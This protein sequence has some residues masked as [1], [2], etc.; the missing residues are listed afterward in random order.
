MDIEE[1]LS[2]FMKLGQKYASDYAGLILRPQSAPAWECFK[3]ILDQYSD[4]IDGYRQAP[5][6]INFR[7]G[8]RLR[9]GH[10][11]IDAGY[12]EMFRGAQYPWVWLDGPYRAD[13]IEF[14]KGRSRTLGVREEDMR[15]HYIKPPKPV[16]LVY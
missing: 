12:P 11:P 9:V 8:A 3:T 6:E 1:A 2:E 7:S 5:C 10:F 13:C 15:L 4:R 14:F 16:S